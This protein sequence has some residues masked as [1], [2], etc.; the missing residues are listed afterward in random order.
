M[1]FKEVTLKGDQVKYRLSPEIK[2]F[3]L[4]DLNF[5]KTRNGN[6]E[7]KQSLDPMEPYLKKAIK[8]KIMISSDLKSFRMS[9]VDG[10]ELKAVDIF[11]NDKFNAEK[12]QFLFY[13][14]NF[15][16]RK[17]FIAD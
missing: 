17:I 5:I 13:M 9:V 7:L 11:S 8:L 4:S 15:I 10:S 16:E 6:F 3:T 1:A 2:L 14:D 12:E